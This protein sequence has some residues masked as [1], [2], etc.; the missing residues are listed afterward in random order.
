M[1][2]KSTKQINALSL[3]YVI[4]LLR[5]G[6]G[7]IFLWAFADKLY[8]LGFSTCRNSETNVVDKMCESAW[9]NGGSPTEGFLNFGTKGPFADF[10][11]SLAGSAF[12]DWLFMLGLL[13]IGASLILGIGVKIAAISGAAML[14]MMYTAVL[15]PEHH[16]IVDDHIIYSLVLIGIVLAN[17][18]QVLGLG[19]WWAKQ[20]LV[21]KYSWL[22]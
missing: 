7:S 18:T 16:P 12:V 8:G 9:I 1:A 20:N 2:R 15:P 5:I 3:D 11:Q 10:Y 14:L 17:G 21:K 6:L 22:Q 19:K 13:L 4:A